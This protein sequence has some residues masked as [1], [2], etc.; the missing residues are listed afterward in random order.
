MILLNLLVK[1]VWIFLIDRQV[2]NMVG[3]EAYGKYFALLNLSYVLFFLSDAG[4]SNLLNQ[5]VAVNKAVNT[6]QYFSLKIFLLALF[7]LTTLFAGW[8]T[9]ITQWEF[10]IYIIAIQSLNSLFIFLRSIISAQQFF[11]ID[12]WLS[13]V[14]K[15]L[16]SVFCGLLIYSSAFGRINLVL[17]LQIQTAC[18][19]V[20]VLIA[21]AIILKRR[22]ITASQ[23]EDTARVIRMITPFAIIILFM[24]V[25]S[26]LDAFLLERIHIN[27]ARQTGIYAMAFRLLEAGN[28]IGYLAAS[29][30]VPF[31]A[32][33]KNDKILTGSV[34]VRVR[35]ALMILGMGMALF[36]FFN[37]DWIQQLLYHSRIPYHSLIIQL[38]LAVL[39][40]SYLIH[41]YSSV[42]T[43]T[44]QFS[45]LITILV[46]SVM[47]NL[48]LNFMLIPAYGA[49]GCC[50]AALASQYFCGIACLLAAS[51]KVSISIGK[52]SI[53][54]Y[55]VFAIVLASVF[56]FGKMVISNV[57]VILATAVFGFGILITTQLKNF[58]KYFISHR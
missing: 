28:M 11:T 4:L 27:G 25:H 16:V 23:K 35:H 49:Q 51:K 34:V 48:V 41:I 14:D 47:I 22:L 44:S 33:N 5:R 50:I 7:I 1:P 19:A 39:P 18:T 36:C 56:Y 29:F 52:S 26:R 42:L 10:L 30:L 9:H 21:L 20:A 13:V 8:L 38:C 32:R 31:I 37:A 46:L 6:G 58:K 45:L 43:A 54:L 55:P 40:A 53:L 57:W 15:L 24:S 12:A 17:F 2:Q 3:H